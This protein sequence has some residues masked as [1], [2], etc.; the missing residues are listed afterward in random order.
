MWSR[1][2]KL[3]VS[4]LLSLAL[5]PFL[6][7]LESAVQF[8]DRERVK[9]RRSNGRFAKILAKTQDTSTFTQLPSSDRKAI[10]NHVYTDHLS[11]NGH[12]GSRHEMKSENGLAFFFF[13]SLSLFVC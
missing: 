5:R 12:G 2:L 6:E 3:N 4:G 13:S 9:S 1:G 11:G 8:P 7:D 10:S